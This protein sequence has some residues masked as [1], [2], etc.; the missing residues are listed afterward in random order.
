MDGARVRVPLVEGDG[1]SA[2][3]L[4]S[5]IGEIQKSQLQLL[6]GL[7]PSTGSVELVVKAVGHRD[8][9]DLNL[10][11]TAQEEEGRSGA[12]LPMSSAGLVP[13][14]TAQSRRKLAHGQV[15]ERLGSDLVGVLLHLM[16][17]GLGS[18]LQKVGVLTNG[19]THGILLV[20]SLD[21]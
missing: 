6:D 16:L 17:H 14:H 20:L 7:S 2:V 15:A 3:L 8:G 12:A 4:Q 10:G 5:P 1:Q 11:R 13:A 18:E 19:K 21:R 9:G